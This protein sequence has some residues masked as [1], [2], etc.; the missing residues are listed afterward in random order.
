MSTKGM[1]IKREQKGWHLK[2][3]GAEN[4][5]RDVNFNAPLF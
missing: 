5:K 2:R 4:A 1:E 3:M